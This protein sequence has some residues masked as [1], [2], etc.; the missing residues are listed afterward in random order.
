M[1]SSLLADL[2]FLVSFFRDCK[3]ITGGGL[4]LSSCMMFSNDFVARAIM[5]EEFGM[6][7]KVVIDL[8]FK[9]DELSFDISLF[10][11]IFKFASG[12]REGEFL[13]QLSLLS[14]WMT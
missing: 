12:P 7:F 6:L 1:C 13:E 8:E 2:K 14:L 10:M 4:L 5:L 11:N 9:V 3:S